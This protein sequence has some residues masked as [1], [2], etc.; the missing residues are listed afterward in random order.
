[1]FREAVTKK[2]EILRSELNG[3]NPTPVERLLAER[4]VLCWL[5]L[6]HLEAVYAGKDSMSLPLALHYQ[7]CIDRAHKRY[8]SA[9]KTL[10]DVRKLGITLQLNIAKKQVNVASGT[11][12]NA[13]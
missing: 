3:P 1:M 11:V 2:M 13:G 12:A 5:H 6:Y 8:L 9:L 7:K 10:A 4:A